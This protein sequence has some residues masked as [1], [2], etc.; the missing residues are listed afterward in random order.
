MR[1]LA[2][3]VIFLASATVQ[4]L[5]VSRCINLGN[6][7]DAPNEGDWGYTIQ[8]H[9]LTRIA[10]A[11]FDTVR[12]PVRFSAHWDGRISPDLLARVD[13]VI[14]WALDEGLTVILDLHHFQPLMENP[15]AHA[16][17][18]VAIWQELSAHYSGASDGLIFELLN[19]PSG[20]LTT[21]K[22]AELY[23]R[24]MPIIRRDNPERWVILGGGHWSDE[25][26]LAMLPVLDDRTAHT[27]HF[28]KPWSFT[29][30]NAP[31]IENPPQ[32]RTW[33][34]ASDRER[35]R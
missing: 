23:R 10:D 24:A 9:H 17:T 12:L 26:E 15:G 13:Q 35:T 25:S 27:F 1:F 2:V 11:G 7:L 32:A 31:W 6:A 3:F 30:Q 16:D 21:A 22:A 14:A 33:G 20:E 28:Y 5:P 8:R 29:H 34:N 19:E 18:F 4:A